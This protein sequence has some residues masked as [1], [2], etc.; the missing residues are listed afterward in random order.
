MKYLATANMLKWWDDNAA[1]VYVAAIVVGW[2]AAFF[3]L[4][5][6]LY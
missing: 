6:W 4:G 1:V 5:A 3:G 2:S